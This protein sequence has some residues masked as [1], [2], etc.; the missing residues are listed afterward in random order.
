MKHSALRRGIA[1]V[2]VAFMVLMVVG[3]LLSGVHRVSDII[4]GMLVSGG[5]FCLYEA[6]VGAWDR[7]STT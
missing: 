4:G 3:R 2:T 7:E 6:A 1:A 5:L